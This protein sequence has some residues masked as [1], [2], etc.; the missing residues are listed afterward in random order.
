MKY[1]YFKSQ[2]YLYE[3][4]VVDDGSKDKTA[5]IT[6]DLLPKIA[7]L[8]LIENKKNYGKGYT[9]RQGLLQAKGQY[10]L[11]TDA[12]NSTS[13]DQIQNFLPE[14]K[15]YH[16]VIGS[17]AMK[18]AVL[19]SP[20]PFLRRILGNIFKIMI[21]MIVWLW[22]IKDTQCGFKVFS[23]KAVN[24]ILSK[25]EING[26]VFDPEILK[27]G[28]KM[29]YK[30]KEIPVVWKNDLESKVKL[31]SAVTTALDLFKI[32]INLIFGRYNLK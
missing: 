9:V 5:K 13:I 4:I 27:I 26:W 29:G 10:R 18:G 8:K 22:K 30:I 3:I 15:N 12:D 14:L 17:R 1:K 25:C 23:E 11:F 24:D 20:Q 2:N 16:I 31:T 21:Q 28:E 32:R 19:N 7:N 6:R